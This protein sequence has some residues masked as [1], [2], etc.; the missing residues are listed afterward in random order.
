MV[1]LR[2]KARGSVT[3]ATPRF[4]STSTIERVTTTTTEAPA[5]RP[6]TVEDVPLE[7]EDERP[8][9]VGGGRRVVTKVG[10]RALFFFF[11][12]RKV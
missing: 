10:M 3:A 2:P 5:M 7:V 11:F 9:T 8:R 4:R 6:G 12:L 1:T